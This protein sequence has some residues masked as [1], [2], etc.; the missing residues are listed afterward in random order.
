VRV[1]L[2]TIVV[3]ECDVCGEIWLPDKRL[4]DGSPN[5]ARKNP[6]QCN[7]CGK[8]KT[9]RWNYKARD[10]KR[11]TDQAARREAAATKATDDHRKT[12]RKAREAAIQRRQVCKRHRVMNCPLC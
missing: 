6:E 7:R 8:C 12:I 1:A 5:P 10:A 4:P 9:P 3:P 2:K 11:V